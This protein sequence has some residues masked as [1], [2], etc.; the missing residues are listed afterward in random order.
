MRVI[1]RIQSMLN[2]LWTTTTGWLKKETKWR[3]YHAWPRLQKAFSF[4][5]FKIRA[6]SYLEY[7]VFNQGLAFRKHPASW[8]ARLTGWSLTFKN[9]LE[10]LINLKTNWKTNIDLKKVH[11]FQ[12]SS[13]WKCST[14]IKTICIFL[15]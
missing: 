1:P 9:D 5:E 3:A 8:V 7:L 13:S 2:Q 15:L 14:K 4:M 12:K 6:P 10:K 11:E